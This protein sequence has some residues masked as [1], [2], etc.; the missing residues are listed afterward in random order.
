MEHKTLKNIY[1]LQ[2]KDLYSAE[3]QLAD[4]LPKMAKAVSNKELKNALREHLEIT[5]VQAARIE[6]I[7]K[8]YA[9]HPS[10]EICNA[11]EGLIEEVEEMMEEQVTSDAI[12]VSLI[13]TCQKIEHFEIASYGSVITYAK[14]L[15]DEKAAE[16]LQ[17]SLDEEYEMDN[18]LDKLAEDI[19]RIYSK[20]NN[21]N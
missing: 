18:K 12:D 19:V 4:S 2:L 13:N 7:F 8:S 20:I 11:I 17:Q 9:S 21:L 15:G 16:I 14:G 5:K 1:L 10:G 6:E 3:K